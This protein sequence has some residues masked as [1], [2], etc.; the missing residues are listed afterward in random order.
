MNRNTSIQLKAALLLMVFGLNTVVGFACAMGL[1]MGFNRHHH[2]EEGSPVIHVHA[3]GKKHQHNREAGK[4]HKSKDEKDDCCN[5]KVA[6]FEQLDKSVPQPIKV[7]LHSVFFTGYP[8]AFYIADVL[9]PS[10]ITVSIKQFV[11]SYH[12]PI[13]DIRIAIQS[14]QV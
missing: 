3:D 8:S 9:Y 13:S 11:R 4:H 5:D 14:F 6:K 10:Q 2:E 7:A 12:P 1:D